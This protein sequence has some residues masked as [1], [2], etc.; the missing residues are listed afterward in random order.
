M[1]AWRPPCPAFSMGWGGTGAGHSP[2]APLST[3][4]EQ[5][6]GGHTQPRLAVATSG[7]VPTPQPTTASVCPLPARASLTLQDAHQLGVGPVRRRQ[8]LGILGPSLSGL[9]FMRSAEAT[10]P[11]PGPLTQIR[12]CGGGGCADFR[13]QEH[14]VLPHPLPMDVLA[15][16]PWNKV[17]WT[18][19]A[20]TDPQTQ[21]TLLSDV[22]TYATHLAVSQAKPNDTPCSPL[23]CL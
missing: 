16:G 13:A 19:P 18:K 15:G 10:E 12:G 7:T 21:A 8:S 4:S 22:L 1:F 23:T 2:Q 5:D 3:G 20:H 9:K 11:W 14:F 6:P 17:T